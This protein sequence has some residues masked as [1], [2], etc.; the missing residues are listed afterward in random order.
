MV[1]GAAGVLALLIAPQAPPKGQ[2]EVRSAPPGAT[3]LIDGRQVETPTPVRVL[4]LDARTTHRVTVR[5][6]GYRTWE[7]EVRFEGQERSR[8]VQAILEKE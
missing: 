7:T 8:A 1:L 4:D 5:Q 3:V 6:T 2:L